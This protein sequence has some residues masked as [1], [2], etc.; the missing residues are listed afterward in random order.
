MFELFAN[1][2]KLQLPEDVS[3]NMTWENP[4]LLQDRIPAPYSMSFTLP[5][6]KENYAA[7]GNPQ[8][9]NAKGNWSDVP[10]RGYFNGVG[11]LNGKLILQETQKKLKVNFQGDQLPVDIRKNLS[12]IQLDHYNFGEG[13]RFFP[14]FASGWAKTYKDTILNNAKSADKFVCCP[15]RVKDEEWPFDDRDAFGNAAATRLYFNFFNVADGD[16]LMKDGTTDIHTAIFPQPLVHYLVSTA[17]GNQLVENPFYSNTELRSLAMITSYHK[18]YVENLM[19]SY[20]GIIVDNTYNES[21]NE[22]S[23][24]SFFNAYPF[25]DFLKDLLKIFCHS[26]MP[27]PDGKWDI[28]HNK[29]ILENTESEDWSSKLVGVPKNKNQPA[30]DYVYGFSGESG[31]N[32]NES[33]VELA[34][35]N[36]LRNP[37]TGAGIYRIASTGEVYE[38][39]LRSKDNDTDPDEFEFKRKKSGL[40]GNTDGDD[41]YSMSTNVATLPM[42]VDEYWDQNVEV[43]GIPKSLWYVPE[44]PDDRNENNGSPFISFFRGWINANTGAKENNGTYSNHYPLLSPFNKDLSGAQCGNYS[45][46]WDSV[47]GLIETWHKEFK[48]YIEKDRKIL[49]G[50]FRLNELDL[51]NLDWKKKIYIRGKKFFLTKIE[52]TIKKRKISLAKCALIEA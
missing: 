15:V 10:S 19:S 7:F 43:G 38:K 35:I 11:F 13:S 47:N 32:E 23:L 40:A 46:Q 48:A 41:T 5:G 18:L 22:M 37:A 17:F 42:T 12:E 14:D 39:K 50:Y 51:K 24:N 1:N 20:K 33:G 3:V 28:V 4:L 45:L 31:A 30:Q 21:P 9:L 16:Y 25:N 29:T 44:F 8:R 27:R 6:T 36:D 49:E 2:K 26:L 34:N 52:V